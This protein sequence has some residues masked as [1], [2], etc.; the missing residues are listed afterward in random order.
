MIDWIDVVKKFEV[1]CEEHPII[2]KFGYGRRD[3]KKTL[4]DDFGKEFPLVWINTNTFRTT[5]FTMIYGVNVDVFS[6]IKDSLTNGD[7][8]ISDMTAIAVDLRNEFKDDLVSLNITLTPYH[9]ELETGENMAGVT[10]LFE[11]ETDIN[12]CKF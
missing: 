2:K 4:F 9:W 3:S 1:V 10:A 6:I 7:K 5:E 11:F 12:N 8:T